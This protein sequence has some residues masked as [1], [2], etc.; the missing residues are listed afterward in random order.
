MNGVIVNYRRSRH[1]QKMD[2]AIVEVEGVKSKDAAEQL[3]GKKVVLHWKNGDLVGKVVSP[4][5]N[6]GAV[7]VRF[8]RG[9][10]GQALGKSVEIL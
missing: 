8:N 7:R 9:I 3:L 6:N 2:Q 10:P 1:N 4:H 5:G